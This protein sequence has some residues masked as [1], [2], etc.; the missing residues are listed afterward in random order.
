MAAVLIVAMLVVAGGA[1]AAA[2]SAPAASSPSAGLA[3]PRAAKVGLSAVS[4]ASLKYGWA[5]GPQAAILRTRDGGRHW[6]R[7]Y[8]Q[9][10]FLVDQTSF[11]SVQAISR[12]TCWVV[13]DGYIYKTV[14][15]GKTWKRMAKKLQADPA[16]AMNSWSACVFAGKVGWVVSGN[17]DII[18]TRNGGT[19]WTRQRSAQGIDDVADPVGARQPPRLHRHERRRRALRAV[20]DRRQPL[21]RR[22]QP[23]N[24]GVLEP[25]LHRH[26]R[27]QREQHL[28]VDE[29][30]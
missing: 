5:V 25:R 9:S 1:A 21:G 14:N 24:V 19:S 27:E 29:Y 18:G 23:P 12:S 8:A 6:T 4:F 10:K 13:G 26:L 16:F 28:P 7:Q 30:R 15:A 2:A 11:T 20:D 3:A 22:E 17:G